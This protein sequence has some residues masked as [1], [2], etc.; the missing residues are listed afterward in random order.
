MT[1][2]II[3]FILFFLNFQSLALAQ[4]DSIQ[5]KFLE[6]K[7]RYYTENCK[8]DSLRAIEESKM[9]NRY[10]MSI[11]APYGDEF[12]PTNELEEIL[13][14]NN[15][16]W[17]G[18][19]MGSD[20]GGYNGECYE[21]S[22]TKATERK[23]GKMFLDNLIKAAVSNYIKKNPNII[24]KHSHY[25]KWNYNGDYLDFLNGA[26]ELNKAFFST[27]SYPNDFQFHK[28]EEKYKSSSDISILLDNKG[29]VLKII[30]FHHHI[31]NSENNKFVP[32]LEESLKKF[33]TTTKFEPAT[34]SGF[35]VKAEVN[36]R[37]FYR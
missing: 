3:I 5:R 23:F 35:P 10:F 6:A 1:M 30:D 4:N 37:I 24:F 12:L 26:D 18:F 9:V 8:K 14:K 28:A 22:H 7:K 34:Y 11:P 29:K 17:A 15:I 25:L 16:I 13:K 36:L 20:I 19:W 33:V 2:K 31:Y 32:Y 27:F 21:L